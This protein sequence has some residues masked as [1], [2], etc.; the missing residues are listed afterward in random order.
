MFASRLRRGV[1]LAAPL[2][3]YASTIT[4]SSSSASTAVEHFDYLVVG[5]GA[6]TTERRRRDANIAVAGEFAATIARSADHDTARSSHHNDVPFTPRDRAI[7]T[8]SN[9]ARSASTTS[10]GLRLQDI[11]VCGSTTTA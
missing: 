8:I 9:I 10:L 7:S 2:A 11:T 4:R 1:V 6:R 3:T 5:G